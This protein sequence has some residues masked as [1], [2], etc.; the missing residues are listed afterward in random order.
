MTLVR[1]V[2]HFGSLDE[3]E[4]ALSTGMIKGAVETWDRLEA[5]LAEG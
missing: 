5:L 2:S 1:A 3:I 4:G